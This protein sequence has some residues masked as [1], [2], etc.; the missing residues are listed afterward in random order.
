MKAR[1]RFLSVILA[2]CMVVCMVPAVA[3]AEESPTPTRTS[4]LRLPDYTE[5]TDK[6][7]DEGWKW[8]PTADGGVLTL[9]D[10]YIQTSSLY[11][12]RFAKDSNVTIILEGENTL[13]TTST[14]LGSM[15]GD[16]AASSS[17]N[18]VIKEGEEGGSLNIVGSQSQNP[19]G[20]AGKSIKIESGTI[21]S[22]VN[23]CTIN[24]DF[25]M[26]NGSLVIDTDS[27]GIYTNRG[28]VT[29]NN[30]YL[31]I[32]SG[33]VGLY[34]P[35]LAGKESETRNVTI[36]GGT[37]KIDAAVS[38]IQIGNNNVF[39]NTCNVLINGGDLEITSGNNGIY[40]KKININSD[41]NVKVHGDACALYAFEKADGIKIEIAKAGSIELTGQQPILIAHDG[42]GDDV[43]IA[44]ANYTEL[45][46]AMAQAGA[47]NPDYYVDFTHVTAAME[48]VD[49]TK[50]LLEQA[51]V[52]AMAQA[53]REA[54]A[55]LE[56]K[57]ANY[58]KVDEAIAKAEAL[59][60]D[61][62]TDF[63]AV[64]DAVSAV[65]RGK[66][67][68][69]QGEVDNMAKAIEDAITN[70]EKKP[71]AIPSEPEQSSEPSQPGESQTEPSK[72]NPNAG[73][74]DIPQTGDN[75]SVLPVIAVMLLAG[76]GAVGTVFMSRKKKYN[77]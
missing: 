43:V 6:L 45:N 12:L 57:A 38:G 59:N 71:A 19:Y 13:E 29:I 75:S 72:D 50:N 76:A 51:E 70:L 11:V 52:D 48:N 34:I 32:T 66:N 28:N 23:F 20:I 60:P 41:G 22:N 69:E 53:V 21:T 40:A 65:V 24:G 56:Y 10:C 73:E 27:D 46:E 9:R 67:I 61:D 16:T 64:E 47:L 17:I 5:V 3:F 62:Y 55:S 31:D 7:E 1:R 35:G 63:S 68:T 26:D 42:E 30:G 36:N 8:E 54:V 44:P 18:L 74:T 2:V 33:N 15:I 4:S 25:I 37:V 39:E 14:T 58:D 77:H 49:Y